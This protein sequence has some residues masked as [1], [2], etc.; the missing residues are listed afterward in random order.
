M[1]SSVL[2]PLLPDIR[3]R[4]LVVDDEPFMLEVMVDMLDERPFDVE[5]ASS[6]AEARKVLEEKQVDLIVSDI[7]MPGA[8]G[9]D[10]MRWCKANNVAAPF[11]LVS[12]YADADLIIEALNL[13][14]RSFISKPFEGDSL[15]KHVDDALAS[16][17]LDSLR[18]RMLKQLEA[19]NRGL[20]ERV[21][22]RTRELEIVKDVTITAL[23]GLA[24]TRDPETGAHI[25]RTRMYVQVLARELQ[26]DVKP[27]YEMDEETMELLYRTAPLH[28]IGKVGVPDSILLKPGKLTDEEFDEMKKHTVYGYNA[29]KRT[30]GQLGSNSFLEYAADIAHQHHEKWNGKGYPQ[31]L[32]GDQI[33][34]SARLMALADVYDALISKRVYKEP[35]THEKASGIITEGRGVH[36]DPVVVDAFERV[37]DEFERIARENSD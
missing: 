12:G 30:A 19:A 33:T 32:E 1:D 25:E 9:V 8:T 3:E 35:F 36:F 14:A 7:R 27:G 17:R 28:D 21:K 20:E 10:L 24:E 2:D 22:E 4:V 37:K 15:T 6:A 29:L 23:A 5:T 13:G 31:N 16:R 18:S 26:H 34:L 11:V